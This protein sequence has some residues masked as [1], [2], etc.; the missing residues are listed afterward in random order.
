MARF[1]IEKEDIRD[2]FLYV[3][4]G[5]H[6]ILH[7]LRLGVGD[8]L[9][10]CD[11]KGTD[12]DCRIEEVREEELVCRAVASRR[13][14]T[15]PEVEITLY[16]GVPK[17]DKMEWIIEKGVE[18]GISRIIPVEMLRSVSRPE[19]KKAEAKTQRWNKIARAAA[20]QSQ[21]GRIPEVLSPQSI[22]QCLAMLAEYDLVLVCYEEERRNS[23]RKVLEEHAHARRIA[24]VIGPEGGLEEEEVQEFT[25]QGAIVV[26]LGP[27]I[28][29]TETAGMVAAS[30]VLYE[31][32]QL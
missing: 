4:E 32:G 12:Y 20:K 14:D 6:H 3:R 24:I 27:R 1:F 11:G 25:A 8:S 2:G 28:L 17:G 7:V 5:A 19:K 29:R 18:C 21:R 31:F 13:A 9:T 10:L 15:E 23:L 22:R 16:Q 26:G 30:L